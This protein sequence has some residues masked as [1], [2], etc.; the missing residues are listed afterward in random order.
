MATLQAVSGT[1]A[2]LTWT[3]HEAKPLNQYSFA[4]R[5]SAPRRGIDSGTEDPKSDI[6]QASHDLRP[7][8]LSALT[9]EEARHCT[10]GKCK[11]GI[12]HQNNPN[13]HHPK[14]QKLE[15]RLAS[16][17]VYELRKNARKK[18]PTFGLKTLTMT[19]WL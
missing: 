11:E 6:S 14:E 2:R 15:G 19:A 9:P 3:A 18:I 7:S 4:A 17:G 13:Q 1:K 8:A 5:V 10:R 12:R 16:P